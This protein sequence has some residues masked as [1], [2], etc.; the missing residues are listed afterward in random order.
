M[1]TANGP[2]RQTD[3][4]LLRPPT[5]ADREGYA[6]E[7]EAEAAGIDWAVDGRGDRQSSEGNLDPHTSGPGILLV[8]QKS[9]AARAVLVGDVGLVVQIDKLAVDLD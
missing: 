1:P 3:R 2:T 6:A 4:L 9:L 5:Q 8:L 7:A